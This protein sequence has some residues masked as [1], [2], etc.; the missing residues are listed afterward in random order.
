[1]VCMG[2]ELEKLRADFLEVTGKPFTHF[3]CP[4]LQADE[5]GDLCMGHIVNKGFPD[6]PED[7]VLQREDVDNFYGAQFE[8][9]FVAMRIQA[10]KS[11][12]EV[13]TDRTL[14]D[15]LKPTIL[16]DNKPVPYFRIG[17]NAPQSFVRLNIEDNGQTVQIGLKMSPDEALAAAD[18]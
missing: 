6:S 11:I 18:K 9:A 2:I 7:E 4:I 12:S 5:P 10:A 8:S 15:Q 17:A 1:M 3:Y 14:S 16:V 13:F